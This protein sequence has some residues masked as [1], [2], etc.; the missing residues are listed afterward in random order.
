MDNCF[1]IEIFLVFFWIFIKNGFDWF[2]LVVGGRI[3]GDLYKE[4]ERGVV[5]V[6]CVVVCIVFCGR[7]LFCLVGLFMGFDFFKIDLVVGGGGGG[8]VGVRKLWER[9]ICVLFIMFI[10]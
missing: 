5:G 7:W 9:F 1:L 3:G 4:V 10:L 2:V 8:V 6:L